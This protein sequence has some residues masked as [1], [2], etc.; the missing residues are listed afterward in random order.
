MNTRTLGIT[1]AFALASAMSLN[2]AAAPGKMAKLDLNGD[3]YVDR[4]EFVSS[5]NKRFAEMDTDANGAVTKDERKAYR[6]LK[7]EERAQRRFDRIDANGDGTISRQ[8]D[9]DARAERD[10]KREARRAERQEKRQERRLAGDADRQKRQRVRQERFKP[11]ANNDGVVD[12]AENIAAAEYRFS[13]MD[14]NGDGLLSQDELKRMKKRGK[15]KH[16]MSGR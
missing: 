4:S 1:F 2:A 7:R 8:E 9:M 11:D 12:V 15:R 5:A 6:S 10:Q 13:Q 16:R 3:S 14:I